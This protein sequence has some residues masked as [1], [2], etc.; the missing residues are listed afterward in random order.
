MQ[1]LYSSLF[2]TAVRNIYVDVTFDT[3]F[4]RAICKFL[5]W[6]PLKRSQCACS[7]SYGNS[8]PYIQSPIEASWS[9]TVVVNLAT[10]SLPP[11][12]YH[13]IVTATYGTFSTLVEGTFIKQK[14][15]SFAYYSIP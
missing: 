2:N 7:I 5:Q 15:T 12:E 3:N 6:Q 11:N 4:T 8:Q 13:F 1:Y 10:E 14:R 9:D